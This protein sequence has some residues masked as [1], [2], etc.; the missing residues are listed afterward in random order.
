MYEID[1]N[2]TKELWK[3][4]CETVKLAE[5]CQK[6]REEYAI[7][8]KTLKIALAE[9]YS[10]DEI[11]ESISEDKAFVKL[12]TLNEEYDTALKTLIIS[13]QTYKGLE[14]LIDTRIQLINFNQSI[15]KNQANK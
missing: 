12:S 10:K 15:I 7:S 13:E 1:F 14:K 5:Q 8:I 4:S 6:A 3:F 9:S 2:D 11:K